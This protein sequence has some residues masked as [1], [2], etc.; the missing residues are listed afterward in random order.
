MSPRTSRS[1]LGTAELC[2]FGQI[3]TVKGSTLE[4]RSGMR[5]RKAIPGSRSNELNSATSKGR[6]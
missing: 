4:V 3:V 2:S 1:R 6:E 5:P